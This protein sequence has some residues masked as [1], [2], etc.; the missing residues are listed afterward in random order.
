M[1]LVVA[2][3]L[4]IK[5]MDAKTTFLLHIIFV[6]PMTVN[7]VNLSFVFRRING[8]NPEERMKIHFPKEMKLYFSFV[9]NLI[10]RDR[11]TFLS[12]KGVTI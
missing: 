4:E 12:V 6:T 8:L 7:D 3:D 9:K 1:S 5:K 10:K 11:R 2:F